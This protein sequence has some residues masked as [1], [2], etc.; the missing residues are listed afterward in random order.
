MVRPS[1]VHANFS[2][3]DRSVPALGLSEDFSY[4][5]RVYA[6]A[7][8]H[9]CVY[10]GIAPKSQVKQTI[11]RHFEVSN[12]CH[13]TSQ[14]RPL[15]VLLVWPAISPSVEAYCYYAFLQRLSV[16]AMKQG[17]LGGWTQ[18]S[19]AVS[20]LG[21]LLQAEA[22]RMMRGQCL[23]CGSKGHFASKCSKPLVGA[24]YPCDCG[25]TAVVTAR[26]QTVL[27]TPAKSPPSSSSSSS[28]APAAPAAPPPPQPQTRKRSAGAILTFDS[29]WGHPRKFRKKDEFGSLDDLLTLMGT[30]AADRAK[31][32]PAEKIGV[33][34]RR[35]GW[36]SHT[37]YKQNVKEFGSR[38][39]G[40]K[41]GAGL[42][43]DAAKQVYQELNKA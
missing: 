11:Q 37:Q 23:N 35:W 34:K 43:K 3:H 42:S 13:Y 16:T 32:R 20:P 10:I 22:S 14:H 33:W 1:E 17:K 24:P 19:S 41:T 31:G 4:D 30:G 6:L 7:L 21:F 5:Y 29:I 39:G 28:A 38:L 18:T 40:G 2:Y 15:R 12:K 36:R 25:G 9:E 26:G 8:Q 27:Q